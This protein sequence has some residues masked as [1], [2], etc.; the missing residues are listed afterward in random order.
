MS[1]TDTADAQ[2]S[3]VRLASDKGTA[4]ME[5]WG[6]NPVTVKAKSSQIILFT[7]ITADDSLLIY[8]VE[9]F[10]APERNIVTTRESA[11][12]TEM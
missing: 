9:L 8:K 4:E 2:Q 7:N 10:S 5:A 11:K 12:L 3:A 6:G 1:G